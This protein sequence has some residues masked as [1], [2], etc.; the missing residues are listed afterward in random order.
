MLA[1]R[2]LSIVRLMLLRC[3]THRYDPLAAR[4]LR[5][6]SSGP[7]GL[8]LPRILQTATVRPCG[9][10]F[11]LNYLQAFTEPAHGAVL[12]LI[13]AGFYTIVGRLATCLTTA[14]SRR[15]LR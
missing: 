1:T 10:K 14:C 3:P 13:T 12:K 5:L 8:H 6:V 11:M 2:C 4:G 9:E 7:A 15:F